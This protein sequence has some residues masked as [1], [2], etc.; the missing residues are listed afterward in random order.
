MH[1]KDLNS[2][3]K[4][5]C[6]SNRHTERHILSY[7]WLRSPRLKLCK[8]F[9]CSISIQVE[10]AIWKTAQNSIITWFNWCSQ[11]H[12]TV[13]LS[14]AV[15]TMSL[16]WAVVPRLSIQ[17]YPGNHGLHPSP[18]LS[19]RNN[20]HTSPTTLACRLSQSAFT[21]DEYNGGKL[22]VLQLSFK[23]MSTKHTLATKWNP[24]NIEHP[25]CFLTY[26]TKVLRYWKDT[27]QFDPHLKPVLVL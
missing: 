27:S 13:L 23:Q 25:V 16:K 21:T 7:L 11:F 19:S 3:R 6:C 12:T 5:Q 18:C 24:I 22:Q 14:S 2:E 1:I 20:S 4:A 10:A 9:L 26:T 15:Y 8:H 17:Q